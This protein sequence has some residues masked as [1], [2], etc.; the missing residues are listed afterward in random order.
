[1]ENL[2]LS[3]KELRPA[4]LSIEG[5]TIGDIFWTKVGKSKIKSQVVDFVKSY[6]LSTG[7][8][9]GIK[10]IAKVHSF[11]DNMQNTWE[12]TF[13]DVLQNKG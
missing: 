7:E 11:S 10:I 13:E 6:S 2:E 12:T 8:T 3:L 9:L 5:V 4:P 1:M